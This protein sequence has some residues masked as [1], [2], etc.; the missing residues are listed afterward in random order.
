MPD[1]EYWFTGSALFQAGITFAAFLL[2]IFGVDFALFKKREWTVAGLLVGA[3]LLSLAAWWNAARDASERI[4]LLKQVA[5]LT[6]QVTE[7]NDQ[8]RAI[9]KRMGI[10]SDLPLS[11][12]KGEIDKRLMIWQYKPLNELR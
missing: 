10:R 4:N 7:A 3:L 12:L 5:A 1:A 8:L 9:A 2:G 6:G 11:D